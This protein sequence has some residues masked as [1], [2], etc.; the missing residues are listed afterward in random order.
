MKKYNLFKILGITILVYFL[1]TWI[2]PA[3]YYSGG[4]QDLGRYQMSI[5]MLLQLPIQ[6]LGY[7]SSTF[8][9]ILSVGSFYGVLE[10]TGLYRKA[11]DCLTKKMEKN[12]LV[13]LLVIMFVIAAISSLAGLELAMFLVFPFL[14]SLILLLGYDKW[15][16]LLATLG[17]TIVGMFGSTYSY[18]LY[19]VNNSILGTA[20][21]DGILMKVILFV[22]GFG[23]LVLFTILHIKKNSKKVKVNK[24]KIKEKA[25]SKIAEKAEKVEAALEKFVPTAIK[26]EKKKRKTWPIVLIIGLMILI[27]ALGTLNWNDAFGITWFNKSY[28]DVMG[29]TIGDFAIFS[30]FFTGVAEFGTWAGPTRFLH[31]A[32]VVVLGT[33]ALAIIYRVKIDEYFKAMFEGAKD[34]LRTALLIMVAYALLVIVSSYPIF[35]TVAKVIVG[36]N[37]NVAT[38]GLATILGSGLYVDPYYYPQYVLQYFAGLENA[39]TT[40]LNVLFVSLY[41]AVMLIVPTGALLLA[42]LSAFETKYKDWIK[43]IWKLFLA[44][45]VVAFIV[46]AVFSV[47]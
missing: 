38:T 3:T 20:M 9:F 1:L 10:A 26:E 44:L 41:S 15:V 30:K 28:A 33:I 37:F 42:T 45:V 8:I 19:G 7:F 32:V 14:I 4:L 39:D 16:A 23:L 21:K 5:P 17:S 2:L 12:K 29:Y 11:L 40:I 18:T 24:D 31:Y 6:T 22:L 43:F 47:I 34:Y 27:F 36:E 35:L 25:K 13:W 46:L